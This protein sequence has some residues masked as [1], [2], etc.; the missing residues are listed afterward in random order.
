MLIS[1]IYYFLTIQ[2]SRG[3]HS[4]AGTSFPTDPVEFYPIGSGFLERKKNRVVGYPALKKGVGYR[5]PDNFLL[6][7]LKYF[8]YI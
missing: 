1:F 6:I 2:I 7:F 5:V 8:I 4:S 3:G